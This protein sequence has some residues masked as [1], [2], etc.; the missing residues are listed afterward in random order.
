MARIDIGYATFDSDSR[1]VKRL[2]G[3]EHTLRPQSAQLLTELARS[4][5]RIVSKRDLMDA[6]WGDIAVTES[7]LTQCVADIRRALGDHERRILQTHPKSGYRLAPPVGNAA[8]V[9]TAIEPLDDDPIRFATSADGVRLAWT[10]S[11]T[12][13]PMLKAP[14]W[15]SN[16]EM[17]AQSLIFTQFYRWLGER[18]RLIRF[19]QRGTSMSDRVEGVLSIDDMV[20][21]MRAVADAAGVE[22][23]FLFGP[24][25]GVAF[26][27]AFAHR[28]P[29]RVI[30]IVGRGGF[31][32][33]WLVSGDE[34]EVRKYEGSKALILAGWNDPNPEYRRFFTARLIPDCSAEAAREFDEMQRRACD[35][36]AILANL[37]LMVSIDIEDMAKEVTTPSL[38]LHSR[39][40]RSVAADEGRR[41]AA[42]MPN[43]DL[44]LLEDD[45][46]IFL[47]GTTGFGQATS[48]IDR[49]LFDLGLSTL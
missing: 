21:D 48:A 13:P 28:Y 27:I 30:G 45:N 44:V 29:E 36:A 20:E 43:A 11:G 42:A 6:V 8:V 49:F 5:G 46:H 37:E 22:L 7:S 41:L 3:E 1:L 39:G 47:P 12:G 33:G 25:Q 17:E 14:S 16:I 23:F 18:V 35:A 10:A 40:D 9:N 4:S 31:G 34:A 15:I 32:R 38:L 26:A 19:D 24:S 2:S